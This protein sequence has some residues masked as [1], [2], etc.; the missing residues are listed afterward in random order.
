MSLLP[1]IS[2]TSSTRGKFNAGVVDT[3]SKFATG[4]GGAP[5]L[6]NMYLREFFEKIR[7]KPYVSFGGLGEDDS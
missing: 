4:V 6:E 3:G 5:C 7:N 2:D 1:F